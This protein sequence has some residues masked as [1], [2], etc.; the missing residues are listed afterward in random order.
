MPL[1]KE[2]NCTMYG[3]RSRQL[4]VHC[5]CCLHM[6]LLLPSLL[7]LCRAS[8]RREHKPTPPPPPTWSLTCPSAPVPLQSTWRGRCR[9]LSPGGADTSPRLSD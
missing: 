3:G 9:L 6:G 5:R 2:H 4:L 8:K 1:V 7:H